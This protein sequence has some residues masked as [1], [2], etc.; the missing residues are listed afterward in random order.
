M[1]EPVASSKKSD[2][3]FSKQERDEAL[4]KAAQF[5]GHKDTA[6][7][8]GIQKARELISQVGRCAE[9]VKYKEEH[10]TFPSAHGGWPCTHVRG[11]VVCLRHAIPQADGSYSFE[12]A[13][14]DGGR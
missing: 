2:K 6:P 1:T 4:A 12:T 9:D 13:K 3:A 5:A 14:L 11:K 8:W 10:G 7:Q